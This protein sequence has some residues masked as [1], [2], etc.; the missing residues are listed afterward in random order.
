MDACTFMGSDLE[1]AL[2]GILLQCCAERALWSHCAGAKGA[3]ATHQVP[4]A[5]AAQKMKFLQSLIM[6]YLFLLSGV[7]RTLF[8]SKR[9]LR[10]SHRATTKGGRGLFKKCRLNKR[11]IFDLNLFVLILSTQ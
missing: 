3:R 5:F 1:P 7:W 10:E 11:Q 6:S 2:H 8:V 4:L 9:E